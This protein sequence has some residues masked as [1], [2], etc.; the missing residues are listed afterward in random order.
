ML[1]GDLSYNGGAVV[2]TIDGATDISLE[3]NRIVFHELVHAKYGDVSSSWSAAFANEERAVFLENA[4][5]RSSFGGGE[6]VGHYGGASGGLTTSS[7]SAV[8]YL[9]G[10]DLTNDVVMGEKGMF[11]FSAGNDSV[12]KAYHQYGVSVQPSTSHSY[13]HYITISLSSSGHIFQENGAYS[14]SRM[15][16]IV[17]GSIIDDALAV[18]S[19]AAAAHVS[20]IEIQGAAND[21]GVLNSTQSAAVDFGFYFF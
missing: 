10:M 15:S 19:Q 4:V 16:L 21:A 2:D 18:T 5:Y 9:A 6:R 1:I 3:F 7:V 17:E 20:A 8:S 14:N 12:K 13:D 11:T